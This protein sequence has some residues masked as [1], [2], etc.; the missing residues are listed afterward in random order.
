MISGLYPNHLEIVPQAHIV[1]T[2]VVAA[3]VIEAP[4]APVKAA[5][6][7]RQKTLKKTVR[8]R[9]AFEKKI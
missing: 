6:A 8:V 5:Q 7:H 4:I 9:K 2:P 1:E 3:P